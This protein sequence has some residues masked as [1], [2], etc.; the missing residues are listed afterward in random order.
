MIMYKTNFDENRCIYFSIKEEKSFIKYMENLEKVR[1]II[2]KKFNSAL[3]YSKKYL[4][5]GEKTHKRRH[6][7]F[8]CTSN[9]DS[10]Y[11][12]EENYYPKV[13]FEKYYFI[14]DIEIFVVIHYYIFSEPPAFGK[15]LPTI[16]QVR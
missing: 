13:F 11:R 15:T 9:I 1:N 6:S 8:I 5:A 12:K 3:I 2:K 10:I 16:A 7:I 14:Q 4:K